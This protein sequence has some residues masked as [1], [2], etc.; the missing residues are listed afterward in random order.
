MPPRSLS[1]RSSPSVMGWS[2][3]Y[4]LSSASFD[5][6]A[7]NNKVRLPLTKS[8][9]FSECNE[10]FEVT[11][12]DDMTNKEVADTWYDAKEYSAIK[13]GY[14]YTIFLMEAGE[15]IPQDDPDNTT[16]GLEYRT[17][18]GAWARYENKRDAYN[19]VLD[20]QDRQW[21][22]DKDDEQRIR[23]IYLDH[24][25]KCADA[26]VV[27]G[28]KDE[29]EAIRLHAEERARLQAAVKRAA[30]RRAKKL[31]EKKK[32]K[33]L[34]SES[35]SIADETKSVTSKKSKVSSETKMK[36]TVMPEK[37]E[38]KL[39][40]ALSSSSLGDR[41]MKGTTSLRKKLERAEAQQ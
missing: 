9:K 15:K 24:S 11:H 14:Q 39:K 5:V 31:A 10:T 30:E 2:D 12:L 25:T 6:N 38:K 3:D 32:L 8:V 40:S 20:E 17:Q 35:K 33:K 36:S 28:V 18:E 7:K 4:S 1:L 37:K 19:A 13:A 21:K 16:R 41:K 22:V 29:R 27:R 34:L 26:A 23:K